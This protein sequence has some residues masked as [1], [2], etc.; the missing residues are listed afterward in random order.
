MVLQ[1]S[2][3]RC[4]PS[5]RPQPALTECSSC[6][7]PCS[8]LSPVAPFYPLPPNALQRLSSR[9]HMLQTVTDRDAHRN[10]FHT[11]SAWHNPPA[12]V[13]RLS[14]RRGKVGVCARTSSTGAAEIT[15][16]LHACPL[17][18]ELPGPAAVPA[19]TGEDPL[20][21]GR[22]PALYCGGRGASRTEL[23]ASPGPHTELPAVCCRRPSAVAGR[24]LSPAAVPHH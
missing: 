18:R 4:R 6:P 16:L 11:V 10:A 17:E 2:R 21:V 3:G 13:S 12:Q 23:A 14:L 5:T 1:Y 24:L 15:R 22:N 8:R 20:R 7:N 19:P 9:R